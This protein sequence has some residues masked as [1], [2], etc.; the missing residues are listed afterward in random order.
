MLPSIFHY[1]EL[2]VLNCIKCLINFLKNTA[3]Y[4]L[5]RFNTRSFRFNKHI[6]NILHCILYKNNGYL[7]FLQL[8]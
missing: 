7:Y 6:Q 3:T 8:N 5:I 1:G 2:F 4:I